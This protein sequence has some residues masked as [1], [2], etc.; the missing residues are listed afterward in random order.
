MSK[1]IKYC[2]GMIRVIDGV[3]NDLSQSTRI[4]LY[5]YIERILQNPEIWIEP[6]K[7][8]TQKTIPTYIKMTSK[9]RK[10]LLAGKSDEEIIV[11]VFPVLYSLTKTY[12]IHSYFVDTLWLN[13]PSYKD[14]ASK[15]A[16][17]LF[18]L[19]RNDEVLGK[20]Q[21]YINSHNVLGHII[22]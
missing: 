11:I 20:I 4:E 14:F 6:L 12:L 13:S 7:D 2:N 22:L 10:A 15:L 5:K 21:Y 8:E 18:S 1:Q 17:N 9:Q 3:L 19:H 16:S